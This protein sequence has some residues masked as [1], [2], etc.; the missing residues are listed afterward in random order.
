MI[1]LIRVCF[2]FYY[3]KH[4]VHLK[5]SVPK[6][7]SK[8]DKERETK[9]DF[10]EKIGMM[11]MFFKAIHKLNEAGM[12]DT[13]LNF[14]FK[15]SKVSL[16]IIYHDGDVEFYIV[17]YKSYVNLVSQHITS[18]YTDAEILIMDPKDTIEI[19][20]RGYTMRTAS[21]NK[22]SDDVFPVKTYKYL[23]DDPLNNFTNVFSGLNREDRAVFQV[24]IKPAGERWSRKAKR[25][26]GLV[27]KGE[28]KKRR[29][30][31]F[32]MLGFL[33]NPVVALVT[34]PDNM[35][36]GN[37][38]PGA[39]EG[40]SYKIFNQA[41]TEA[42]KMMGEAASQQTYKAAIRVLVSS[43]QDKLAEQ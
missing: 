3:A 1:W 21:L 26:A 17:T 16:E 31:P 9:K 10:K 4:L 34:G 33:W 11:N 12:R 38:A 36:G 28:Y 24:A 5:V 30:L 42:Q 2:E 41:E 22:E 32:W 37:N 29:K 20:P 27:A 18:V 23:E 15:H 25:A 7:D 14:F 40:D 8:L 43:K 6:S 35:V 13:I 19:K 39:S